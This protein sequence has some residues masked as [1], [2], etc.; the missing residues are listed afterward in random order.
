MSSRW[1]KYYA[2]FIFV[3]PYLML[4]QISIFSSFTY[5][6]IYMQ[7]MSQVKKHTLVSYTIAELYFTT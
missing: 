1:A 3:S 4:Y 6:F 2:L 5:A 7:P